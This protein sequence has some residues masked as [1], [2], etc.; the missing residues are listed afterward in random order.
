M[1][2]VKMTDQKNKKN[3]QV[4]WKIGKTRLEFSFVIRCIG[5]GF[6]YTP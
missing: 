3:T 2:D 6:I 4:S 5:Q 1:Q